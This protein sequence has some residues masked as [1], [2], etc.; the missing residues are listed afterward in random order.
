MAIALLSAT[1]PSGTTVLATFDVAPVAAS[2][3]GA[4]DWTVVPAALGGAVAVT[5]AVVQGDPKQV[6]LTVTPALTGGASYTVTAVDAVDGGGAPAIPNVAVAAVS[7]AFVLPESTEWPAR[8]L[9]SLL[10]A[11]GREMQILDGEPRTKL[12]SALGPSDVAA[13]VEST[14]GFPSAGGGWIG[15]QRCSWTAKA[16]QTLSGLT[17]PAPRLHTVPAGSDVVLDPASVGVV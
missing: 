2:V 16:Q 6:L 10:H 14:L 3:N 8:F 17:F 4:D 7:T 11:F 9:P 12:L 1:A 5:A 13:S 15:R